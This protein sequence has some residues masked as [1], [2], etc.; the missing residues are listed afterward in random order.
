MKRRESCTGYLV[1]SGA[2]KLVP[3]LALICAMSTTDPGLAENTLSDYEL[4]S[5]KAYLYHEESGT[6]STKDIISLPKGSLWNTT[7][8][9]GAAGSPSHATLVVV[10]ITGKPGSYEPKRKVELIAQETGKTK[11]LKFK[12]TAVLGGLSREGKYFAAFW[13]YDTGCVPIVL[14][15]RLLGQSG[16]SKSGKVIDFSCGE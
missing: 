14:S 3:V 9:A 5:L 11:T 12:K 7:I 2:R 4:S 13:L 10:E 8:G 6:V 1:C 15:A 16:V